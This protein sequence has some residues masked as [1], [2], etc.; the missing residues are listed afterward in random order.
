MQNLFRLIYQKVSQH[1]DSHVMNEW[2]F[3]PKITFQ[4]LTIINVYIHLYIKR[5]NENQG[6]KARNLL[7]NIN[8]INIIIYLLIYNLFSRWLCLKLSYLI[9]Q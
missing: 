1:A 3:Y 4:Q 2:L 5:T 8:I 9:S 6:N 7:I